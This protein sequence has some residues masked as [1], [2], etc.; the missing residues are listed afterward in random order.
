LLALAVE[1]ESVH[2]RCLLPLNT[3]FY[4][5]D[6]NCSHLNNVN[7]RK[8]STAD[9]NHRY[10]RQYTLLGCLKAITPSH[11]IG[12]CGGREMTR[13]FES[14]LIEKFV[15]SLALTAVVPL[16][17]A[18]SQDNAPNYSRILAPLREEYCISYNTK[19][20]AIFLGRMKL[21]ASA[22]NAED[23]VRF[24]LA[25]MTLD[26]GYRYMEPTRITNSD[27]NPSDGTPTGGIVK[28]L[29]VGKKKDWEASATFYDK[30]GATR[31]DAL[32]VYNSVGRRL[33][34]ENF[35]DRLAPAPVSARKTEQAGIAF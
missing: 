35:V 19:T 5:Y 17:S 31:I 15:I 4:R 18:V 16:E 6:W 26:S 33:Y 28:I 13:F 22:Q 29:G 7:V 21:F 3:D 12:S 32:E 24:K 34:K 9:H 10:I 1:V 8:I 23:Y 20:C 11:R 25:M 30:P 14:A 2:R 27:Y